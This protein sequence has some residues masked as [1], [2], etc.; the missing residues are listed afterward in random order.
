MNRAGPSYDASDCRP[1][2]EAA[3]AKL[4]VLRQLSS[5]TLVGRD[6]EL[7]GLQA[8]LDRSAGGTGGTMLLVAEA[9]GGKTRLAREAAARAEANGMVV[10]WGM[11]MEATSAVPLLPVVEAMNNALAPQHLDRLRSRVRPAHRLAAL[12]VP[13]LFPDVALPEHLEEAAKPMLFEAVLEIVGL[14]GDGALLVLD[15]AHWAD[16]TT[17]QLLLHCTNRTPS[18]PLAVLITWRAGVEDDTLRAFE[19]LGMARS[20][21]LRPLSAADVARLGADVLG[22]TPSPE[23]VATITERS[24][25]NPFAATE[26]FSA[27]ARGLLTDELPRSV[28]EAVLGRARDLSELDE[29]LLRSAAVLGGESDI[30]LLCEM[31]VSPR[32][33]AVASLRRLVGC[34][35]LENLGRGRFAFRH[36][37]IAGAVLSEI[38]AAELARLHAAAAAALEAR[39]APGATVAH[40]LFAAG[41]GAEAVPIAVAAAAEAERRAGYAEASSLYERAANASADPAEVGHLLYKAAWLA[42]RS[43][44]PRR[45]PDLAAHAVKV[46]REAGLPAGHPRAVLGHSMVQLGQEDAGHAELLAAIVELDLGGPSPELAYA[47]WLAGTSEMET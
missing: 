23:L 18:R 9:G 6:D 2:L 28:R 47:L 15:D 27:A 25:G 13:E 19:R 14:L 20:L 12:V 26:L 22:S 30:A 37:L 16:S 11:G 44:N 10:V 32:V 5:S 41:R 40:H 36:T 33:E 45:S 8:L 24:A 3:V 39:G 4:T 46:L 35:L 17:Q 43:V 1:A 34:G 38:E 29:R 7:A 31:S 42:T 21:R